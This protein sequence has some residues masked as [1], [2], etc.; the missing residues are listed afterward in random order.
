MT[1]VGVITWYGL[2]FSTPEPIYAGKRLSLWLAEGPSGFNDGADEFLGKN[3]AL[4]TDYLIS[5][6]RKGDNLF[7]KP[8]MWLTVHAPASISRKMPVWMEPKSVRVGAT[9]WLAQLGARAKPA[10]AD[11]SRV[12]SQD[13]YPEVRESALWALGRVDS[14]S[15]ETVALFVTEL[16]KDK[17]AGVRQ[18]AV[19]VLEIWTPGDPTVIP[20]LIKSLKDSDAL[21]RQ[22]SAAALGK[23]GNAAA[24]ALGPLK[25]LAGSNDPAADYAARAWEQIHEIAPVGGGRTGQPH[26]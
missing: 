18:I 3:S 13:R 25:D 14:A 9:Y 10:V 15:K 26:P 19:G 20:A 7:W 2:R 1:A 12:G 21:V 17:D 11:L 6:L 4:V 22:I 23:Y 5:T 16:S 8:Y 24:A